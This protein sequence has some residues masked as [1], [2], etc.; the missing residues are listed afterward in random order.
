MKLA[1]LALNYKGIDYETT[2]LEYP[3]V[4]PT[5]KPQFVISVPRFDCSNIH[6]VKPN[7]PPATPYTIPTI[8]LE[9]GEYVM[10]SDAIAARLERDHPSPSLHLDSPIL[11]QV[12]EVLTKIQFP[13]MG[14]WMP[15]VPSILN[16][17]SR[18]YFERTR[19]ERL[20]K[21]L[22]EFSKTNGGE[23]AWIEAL[24]GIIALG[25]LIR[26]EGGPYVMGKERKCCPLCLRIVID[27]VY[28][29]LRGL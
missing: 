13:L 12:E 24:P 29:I 17:R 1:R 16:E 10:D 19:A 26:K 7:S 3:D 4:E 28:S 21:S 22:E 5:L 6:S 25:E 9:S 18:E 11:A 20:G 15:R 27:G 23:E 14:V 2:W 8:R